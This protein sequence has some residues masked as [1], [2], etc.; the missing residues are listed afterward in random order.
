LG[1]HPVRASWAHAGVHE[2]IAGAPPLPRLQQLLVGIPL[3]GAQARLELRVGVARV[4]EQDVGIEVAPGERRVREAPAQEHVVE[5]EQRDD[6]VVLARCGGE[7][8]VVVA[9]Q[10]APEPDD[11]G[12][13]AHRGRIRRRAR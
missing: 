1:I 10:V 2:R 3:Q 12:T 13:G 6:P 7:R 5:D 8:R 4:A 11:R 9:A